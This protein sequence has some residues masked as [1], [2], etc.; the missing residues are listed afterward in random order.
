SPTLFRSD[1]RGTTPPAREAQG[2][3]GPGGPGPAALRRPDRQ[4]RGP[5]DG[6]APGRHTPGAA[7]GAVGAWVPRGGD[8]DAPPGA[9]WGDGTSVHHAH[10]CLRSRP[11]PAY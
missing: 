10:Q 6:A 11:L 1:V 4:P 2:A 9:R 7:F 5:A 8:P 3:G